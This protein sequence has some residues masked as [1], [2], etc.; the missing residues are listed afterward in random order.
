[1]RHSYAVSDNPAYIDQERPLTKSGID[2][3]RE[4]IPSITAWPVQ[5]II[6]SSAVRTQQTA[7]LI[8]PAFPNV[9]QIHVQEELYL[10]TVEQYVHQLKNLDTSINCAMLV[11]HN[12]SVANLIANWSDQYH[13]VSPCTICV[14]QFSISEW[15]SLKL[16]NSQR[17]TMAACISEGR[18]IR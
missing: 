10:A 16:V 3:V 13:S 8:L 14:F 5:T 6:A 1:M 18:Q 12:P 9:D 7:E 15:T 17:P 4:T 11:G 2:L